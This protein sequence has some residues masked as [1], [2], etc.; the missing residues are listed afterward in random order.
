MAIFSTSLAYAAPAHTPAGNEDVGV[1][2]VISPKDVAP[3]VSE[4]KA[5][6]NNP[7]ADTL[8]RHVFSMSGDAASYTEAHDFMKCVNHDVKL[9]TPTSCNKPQAFVGKD[10]PDVIA[11]KIL[12]DAKNP[13]TGGDKI[14]INADINLLSVQEYSTPDKKQDIQLPVITHIG[15]S[16]FFAPKPSSVI[17]VPFDFQ[18]EYDVTFGTSYLYIGVLKTKDLKAVS[19]PPHG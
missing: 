15:L 17:Q 18:N 10:A 7:G 5:K 3:T 13:I 14:S 12:S 19:N 9:N 2:V 8:Y 16:Q 11:A 6:W 1:I 4:M